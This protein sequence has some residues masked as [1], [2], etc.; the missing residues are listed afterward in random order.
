[1]LGMHQMAE[2]FVTMSDRLRIT[3]SVVGIGGVL[4]SGLIPVWVPLPALEGDASI[5]ADWSITSDGI[6]ARLAELL[7]CAPLVLLKSVDGDSRET[8]QALAKAGV[9]DA[10]FPG[11]AARSRLDWRIFGP[12]N[13]A[14][15]AA[16]LAEAPR[17]AAKS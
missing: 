10:A 6:A 2:V 11:I 5:P 12:A 8:A 3:G 16:L 17:D 1:M 14:E 15:F 4:R 9:I 13:D 7:G